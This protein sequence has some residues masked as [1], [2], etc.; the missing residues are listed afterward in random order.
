MTTP[1]PAL[2]VLAAAMILA[3]PAE[4]AKVTT[5]RIEIPAGAESQAPGATI[6]RDGE[7]GTQGEQ[8]A[9]QSMPDEGLVTGVDTGATP[10]PEIH[11]GATGLPKPVMRLREQIL[12]AARTGD[13][14]RLR[15]V[16]ESNE[17]PPTL[18]LSQ[19]NDPID[20]LKQ[21]SGDPNGRE[22]LAI[23]TEILEAGWVH[24]DVG[25]PQEMY[26]WPY[27]ARYPV[28]KLTPPQEVE[29]Y[30]ILTAADVEEMQDFG[31]YIFY[32]VGIGPDGTWHYF[33]AGD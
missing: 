7:P 23:L 15:P 24:V 4:A 33:V 28:N 13:V 17:M 16:L 25:T 11:Y 1:F 10:L 21:S 22:L 9:P 8:A 20:F 3:A 14:E 32:R 30:R 18:S 2:A 5:Q 31:A 19:I 29:L 12:D 27:F 26:I 6:P